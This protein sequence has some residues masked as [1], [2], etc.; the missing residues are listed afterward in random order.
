M[1]HTEKR[2]MRDGYSQGLVEA[3]ME[4]TQVVVLTG[5]L[6]ESTRVNRF[7]ELFPER[8]VQVGIAE[9]NMIGIA[10]GLALSGKVPFVSTYASFSPMRSLDQIRVS[11]CFQNENVKIVSTHAGL[12]TGPDGATAQALED[13]AVM[14]VLPN[15]IVIVPCDL[16]QAKKATIALS[17]HVGPAYMRLTRDETPII[18]KEHDHFEIGKADVLLEGRDITLIACGPSVYEA[19]MAAKELE[20][21][22]ILC[23]VI[24]LS[25]IKPLDTKTLLTSLK[26]TKK[27][28]TI[29]DHQVD[30][31]MGS[32]V[33]EFFSENHPILIQR[34]G[35]KDVFGES[36]DPQKL[37]AKHGLLAK[38]IVQK[39][40]SMCEYKKSM[41]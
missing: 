39:V 1:E 29:E 19:M 28:I 17:K 36:G 15:M 41:Y 31:G 38:D 11:V 24:N 26:K 22:H 3:G 10:S 40:K 27:A 30:G 6:T 16:Y 37:Y 33:C 20:K 2:L 23:E 13:I 4:N 12:G 5:D 32:A 21:H 8:F 35:V 34:M 18:T 25:T 9:Q 14:R 7:A